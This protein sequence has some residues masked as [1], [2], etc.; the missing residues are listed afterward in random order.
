MSAVEVFGQVPA[1]FVGQRADEAL[2]WTRG[3]VRGGM[4]LQLC[5]PATDKVALDALER[6]VGVGQVPLLVLLGYVS[7][8]RWGLGAELAL[9]LGVVVLEEVVVDVVDHVEFS[10]ADRAYEELLVVGTCGCSCG[11]GGCSC[12]GR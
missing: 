7:V 6:V 12:C 1:P 8:A 9:V 2:E 10:V 4:L 11:G 5:R 3:R